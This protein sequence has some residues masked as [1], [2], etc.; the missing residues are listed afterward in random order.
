MDE[1]CRAQDYNGDGDV[2]AT[3]YADFLT[4]MAG[5]ELA[6]MSTELEESLVP[7]DDSPLELSSRQLYG[8]DQQG[9]R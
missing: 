6:T 7:I 8:N 3:D 1:C 2:D 9:Y 5:P 4:I